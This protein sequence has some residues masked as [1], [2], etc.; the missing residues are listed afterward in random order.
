MEVTYGCE[1]SSLEALAGQ[2]T[3]ALSRPLHRQESPRTGAWYSSH[4]LASFTRARK[5]GDVATAGRIEEELRNQPVLVVR[6]GDA[7]PGAPAADASPFLL[8]TTAFTEQLE[9]LEGRL[10]AAGV[11]FRER[12]RALRP[13]ARA[14][15]ASDSSKPHRP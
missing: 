5:A 15:A 13:A 1:A 9:D 4:D 8:T 12:S 2:V 7:G 10:R 6:R 11:A 3:A 14:Q